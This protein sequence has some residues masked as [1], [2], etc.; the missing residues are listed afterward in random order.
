MGERAIIVQG[1]DWYPCESPHSDPV[2]DYLIRFARELA[3]KQ[4]DLDPEVA[5]AL[6]EAFWELYEPI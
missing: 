3:A 4:R 5:R 2:P 6:N 1:P